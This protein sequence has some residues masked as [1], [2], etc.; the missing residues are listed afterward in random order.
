MALR[1]FPHPVLKRVHLGRLHST[2]YPPARFADFIPKRLPGVPLVLDLAA[3]ASLSLDDI[4]ENDSLGDCV[5]AGNQHLAGVWTGN[6]TGTPV[7]FTSDQTNANYTGMSGGVFNPSDPSTDQGCEPLVALQWWRANGLLPDGSHK[8][9]GYLALDPSNP[10]QLRSAAWLF[11]GGIGFALD[12][13]DEY[14][15]PVPAASGFIW[16]SSGPP[17]PQN[18]HWIVGVGY[19]P[20]AF[21]ISTWGM[22]GWFTDAAIAKYCATSN[23][24]EL[25]ATISTDALVRAMLKAPNGLDWPQMTK[26]FDGAGENA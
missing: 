21:K 20:G 24:G 9:A 13:P 22:T 23:G 4:F 1:S 14:V 26:Y 12:L 2:G 19:R 10:E 17:D 3:K 8:I 7:M 15:N 5:V 16:D 11:E 18:G 25:Y 6:A